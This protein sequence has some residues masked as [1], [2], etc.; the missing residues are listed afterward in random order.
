MI[1]GSILTLGERAGRLSE[2]AATQLVLGLTRIVE[3]ARAGWPVATGLSRAELH[4]T[5]TGQ[6]LRVRGRAR[7]TRLIRSR[8]VRPWRDLIEVP[9][10]TYVGGRI[11]TR[12]LGPPLMRTLVP[13]GR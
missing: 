12:E 8:G 13:R 1:R 3:S 6:Q 7:Y 11:A 9:V 4:L 10:R 5:R 2:A